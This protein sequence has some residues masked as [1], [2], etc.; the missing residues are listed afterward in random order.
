MGYG[1]RDIMRHPRVLIGRWHFDLTGLKLAIQMREFAPGIFE[2]ELSLEK[3]R[4]AENV[5]EEHGQ[6]QQKRRR[7]GVV[8][9]VLVRSHELQLIEQ[10]EAVGEQER[11]GH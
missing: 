9:D 7:I 10:P 5:Q 6:R 1:L 3:K 11:N 4:R 8:Q 2:E